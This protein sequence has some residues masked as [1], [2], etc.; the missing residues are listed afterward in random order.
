METV[1]CTLLGYQFLIAMFLKFISCLFLSNW[2]KKTT[3]ST[4]SRI[5][6]Y[7]RL[8]KN[9]WRL[10]RQ[11]FLRWANVNFRFDALWFSDDQNFGKEESM[12][13]HKKEQLNNTIRRRWKEL[14]VQVDTPVIGARAWKCC[15]AAVFPEFL[16]TNWLNQMER[17]KKD[18]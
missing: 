4:E 2:V 5:R 17:H 10:H 6:L 14:L 11:P 18:E 13:R 8:S 12:W 7:N 15:K 16:W 3:C 9:W 1:F